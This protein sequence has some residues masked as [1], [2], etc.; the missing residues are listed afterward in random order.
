MFSGSASTTVKGKYTK[1]HSSKCSSTKSKIWWPV[2]LSSQ[3][4]PIWVTLNPLLDHKILQLRCVKL[5]KYS[6]VMISIFGRILHRTTSMHKWS[7]SHLKMSWL[8]STLLIKKR[9]QWNSLKMKR[10][11]RKTKCCLIWLASQIKEI[12]KEMILKLQH[13]SLIESNLIS[14]QLKAK[15]LKRIKPKKLAEL[16]VQPKVRILRSM[17]LY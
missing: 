6:Q 4:L 16:K 2:A 3:V 1:V 13:K 10:W 9:N 8:L 15:T 11:A 14:V 12:Q 5:V 17:N 7:H